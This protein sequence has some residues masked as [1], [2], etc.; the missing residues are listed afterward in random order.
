MNVKVILLLLGTALLAAACDSGPDRS[1]ERSAAVRAKP[2]PAKSAA[3]PDAGIPL[4]QLPPNVEP[5][6]YRVDLT[7]NPD[8]LRYEGLVEIDIELKAPKREIYLHGKDLIVSKIVAR[9]SGR[10]DVRGTYTQVD[11]MASRAWIS[12][13]SC[14]PASSPS[15]CPFPP[16]TRPPL[17][18]LPLRGKTASAMSGRSSRRSRRAARSPASTNRASR[19]LSISR[20]PTL[21]A[22]SP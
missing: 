2:V 13:S 7:L 8:Q 5:L 21:V 22:M 15:P 10:P 3:G 9:Q 11:P 12:T 14:H 17:T 6:H 4:G 16:P 20:S 1:A 19:H 18:H